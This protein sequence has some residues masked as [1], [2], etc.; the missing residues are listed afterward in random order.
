MGLE[1]SNNKMVV[2]HYTTGPSV[3]F[4]N[5]PFNCPY[6]LI[7]IIRRKNLMNENLDSFILSSPTDPYHSL[8]PLLQATF[9]LT[10][11]VG[12]FF[13]PSPSAY[14]SFSPSSEKM[15][16]HFWASTRFLFFCFQ[17]WM[18]VFQI[19]RNFTYFDWIFRCYLW[20]T[21][22]NSVRENLHML[23]LLWNHSLFGCFGIPTIPYRICSMPIVFGLVTAYIFLLPPSSVGMQYWSG[24]SSGSVT[25]LNPP[26]LKP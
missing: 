26:Y 2:W 10:L 5:K 8:P 21:S 1:P 3:N 4:G 15:H 7:L 14:P 22:G 19:L 24:W 11:V 13:P 18:E 12:A 25:V 6:I 16:H 17:I 20:G 9:L 23:L